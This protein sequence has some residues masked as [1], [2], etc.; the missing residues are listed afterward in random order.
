MWCLFSKTISDDVAM[1]GDDPRLFLSVTELKLETPSIRDH[2]SKRT[3]CCYGYDNV[4]A[5]RS[6]VLLQET[7]QLP[8]TNQGKAFCSIFNALDLAHIIHKILFLCLHFVICV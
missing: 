8:Q 2:T 5:L 1:T 4:A 7:N 6:E 3:G